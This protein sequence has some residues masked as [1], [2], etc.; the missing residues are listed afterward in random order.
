MFGGILIYLI[1]AY[2]EKYNCNFLLN[3]R[4]R[5]IGILLIVLVMNVIM[6]LIELLTIKVSIL[7]EYV[8]YFNNMNNPFVLA[9]TVLIF[10]IFKNTEIKNNNFI[11]KIAS[12]TLGIYLIHENVFLRDVIWKNIINVVQYINSPLL[13]LNA[14]LGVL[15]VFIIC[16]FIDLIFE[17]VINRNLMQL[18]SKLYKRVKQCKIYN[19]LQKRIINYYN[20]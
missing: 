2:I 1:G 17:K 7:T 8:Y 9:L 5:I 11:N 10:L 16:A 3:N 13:I 18:I 4:N 14:I 15:S 19:V 20:T 6:I 12:T